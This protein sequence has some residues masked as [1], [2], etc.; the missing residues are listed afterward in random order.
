MANVVYRLVAELACL[1]GVT[2]AAVLAY[3]DKSPWVWVP[4]LIFGFFNVITT[5]KKA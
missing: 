5:S 3:H 4:F 1:F 2:A